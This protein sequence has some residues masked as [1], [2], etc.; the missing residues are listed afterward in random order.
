MYSTLIVS[1]WWNYVKKSF[2]PYQNDDS[3]DSEDDHNDDDE[4]SKLS[5]ITNMYAWVN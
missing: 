5:L 2:W 3:C 4:Q 1:I